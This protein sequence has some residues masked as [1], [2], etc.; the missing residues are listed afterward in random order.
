MPGKV[1]SSEA[2]TGAADTDSRDEVRKRMRKE[3]RKLRE[4]NRSEATRPRENA[5]KDGADMQ[6]EHSTSEVIRPSANASKDM[7]LR[8]SALHETADE[9]GTVAGVHPVIDGQARGGESNGEKRDSPVLLTDDVEL[10][11]SPSHEQANA[12]VDKD[13]EILDDKDVEMRCRTPWNKLPDVSAGFP[14]DSPK[15]NFTV[16]ELVQ[17]SEPTIEGLQETG[18]RVSAAVA[19]YKNLSQDSEA[20]FDKSRHSPLQI[21]NAKDAERGPETSSNPVDTI[22]ELMSALVS[23][24]ISPPAPSDRAPEAGA[25]EGQN[26]DGSVEFSIQPRISASLPSIGASKS[27]QIIMSTSRPSYVLP[28][29]A[30]DNSPGKPKGPETLARR[31]SLEKT[32][33][34][35][36][37][38]LPRAG[39]SSE[40]LGTLDEE[41]AEGLD[42]PTLKAEKRQPDEVIKRKEEGRYELL[43][44]MPKEKNDCLPSDAVQEKWL[45]Q[46]LELALQSRGYTWSCITPKLLLDVLREAVRVQSVSAACC[47]LLWSISS[48]LSIT[49]CLRG[50]ILSLHD[51]E[52]IFPL[53]ESIPVN[54]SSCSLTVDSLQAMKNHSFFRMANSLGVLWPEQ[55]FSV[56]PNSLHEGQE[57]GMMWAISLFAMLVLQAGALQASVYLSAAAAADSR[58]QL[59]SLI[60][61]KALVSAEFCDAEMRDGPGGQS[62]HRLYRLLLDDV[63]TVV[64]GEQYWHVLYILPIHCLASVF[65]IMRDMGPEP[66]AI[67]LVAL[68]CTACIVFTLS[69]TLNV[70]SSRSKHPAS[71]LRVQRVYE[72]LQH[73]AYIAVLGWQDLFVTAIQ[74]VREMERERLEAQAIIKSVIYTWAMVTGLLALACLLLG[75]AIFERCGGPT[76]NVCSTPGLIIAACHTSVLTACMAL[77]T[78]IFPKICE[79]KPSLDRVIA[80]LLTQDRSTPDISSKENTLLGSAVMDSSTAVR[81]ASA[82][83][84]WRP[85][86]DKRSFRIGSR[87]S[88]LNLTLR[89]REVIGVTSPKCEGKSSFLCAM[90]G[91]MPRERGQVHVAGKSYLCQPEPLLIDGT[92]QDNIL[93]GLPYDEA[94]YK[95]ALYCSCLEEKLD[96][97]RLKDLT[98][99]G[100]DKGMIGFNPISGSQ[101]L[102]PSNLAAL[103]LA[104]AL[105][106]NAD[107]YLF[108]NLFEALGIDCLTAWERC[109]NLQL[110]SSTVV[111][112]CNSSVRSERILRMCDRVIVLG[113]RRFKD[114]VPSGSVIS[115]IFDMGSLTELNHRGID[116]IGLDKVDS[117]A[118]SW[119]ILMSSLWSYKPDSCTVRLSAKSTMTSESSPSSSHDHASVLNTFS[120]YASVGWTG[121]SVLVS[122]LPIVCRFLM[123]YLML[124]IS[125]R[126]LIPSEE[127]DDGSEVLV[128]YA[129]CIVFMCMLIYLVSTMLW[130]RSALLSTVERMHDSLLECLRAAKKLPLTSH[131]QWAGL[132]ADALVWN[133]LFLDEAV[134]EDAVFFIQHL[135]CITAELLLV[136]YYISIIPITELIAAPAFL[137]VLMIAVVYAGSVRAHAHAHSHGE[138]R[139]HIRDFSQSTACGL[140]LIHTTRCLKQFRLSMDALINNNKIDEKLLSRTLFCMSLTLD[141]VAALLVLS[142]ALVAILH[143]DL[144]V[145]NGSVA[146]AVHIVAG[147]F[148]MCIYIQ[149][150]S[151]GTSHSKAIYDL[152]L[153]PMQAWRRIL[154]DASASDCDSDNSQSTADIPMGPLKVEAVTVMQDGVVVLRNVDMRINTREYL[155]ILGSS[156]SGKSTLAMC[157][158]RAIYPVSGTIS[159]SNIDINTLSFAALRKYV[160]LVPSRPILFKGS[161]LANLDPCGDLQQSEILPLLIAVGLIEDKVQTMPQS[162][163]TAIEDVDRVSS[164]VKQLICLC[165]VL[166]RKP[167]LLILDEFGSNIDGRR[168]RQIDRFLAMQDQ[169]AVLQLSRNFQHVQV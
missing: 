33:S 21:T 123:G 35:R 96:K 91:V 49:V 20:G 30:A 4:E 90:A 111:V 40:L 105:Y 13:V 97:L 89:K 94:M 47:L 29:T 163:R 18:S 16:H 132:G 81:I 78:L 121:I 95:R 127:D 140:F 103:A 135:G 38:I 55:D 58:A 19:S 143:H 152:Y 92:I 51:C 57:N 22:D 80:F 64:K 157:I 41:D 3:A 86:V 161:L 128:A 133:I 139:Q 31:N 9:G 155:V 144:L 122:F 126:R 60:Y 130:L 82:T 165:R 66:I 53:D 134:P 101:A 160:G 75:G 54:A 46:K 162:M 112:S 153:A 71:T 88:E 117:I 85:K 146:L 150:A 110:S 67:A 14:T 156:G 169:F 83:F 141:W 32:S 138:G 145:T 77:M 137:Q 114:P 87:G 100:R 106:V 98:R 25:H 61:G 151:Y 113:A 50:L 120:E 62:S 23:M 2:S 115:G 65:L 104:R 102:D 43:V 76:Q 125:S 124:I 148:Q 56:E 159:V 1:P 42:I 107:L 39:S 7:H 109:I 69:Y 63:D 168:I 11:C 5:S 8:P 73:Y 17:E 26:A 28:K 118:D 27:P 72:L 74:E 142:T 129:G 70:T 36:V 79:C 24:P 164:T 167:Q 108:D 59:M 99:V 131:G 37:K 6:E 149:F 12:N 52:R 48:H 166:L 119:E 10:Q 45:S 116:V 147:T 154:G 93:F 34:T 84:V 44:A 158:L 68:F 15:A 136:Y